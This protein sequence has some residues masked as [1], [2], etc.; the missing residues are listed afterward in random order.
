[1]SAVTRGL[2]TPGD[3]LVT[4]GLGHASTTVSP[5]VNLPLRFLT[6]ASAS[7]YLESEAGASDTVELS[8]QG[9][10]APD[11]SV[12]VSNSF[13]NFNVWGETVEDGPGSQT[14][15]AVASLPGGDLFIRLDPSNDRVYFGTDQDLFDD[16]EVPWTLSDPEVDVFDETRPY[17][18]FVEDAALGSQIVFVMT[19]AGRAHVFTASP[20]DTTARV[21]V[22][23]PAWR[24]PGKYTFDTGYDPTGLTFYFDR[25]AG[26]VKFIQSEPT[27]GVYT[28]DPFYYPDTPDT[29]QFTAWVGRG[30]LTST[31][32][33]YKYVS[34]V[35]VY[36]E[37]DPAVSV[38]TEAE[39][40]TA[41][42][43]APAWT[44]G[45]AGYTVTSVEHESQSGFWRYLD[46]WE[47]WDDY[48][49]MHK[50]RIFWDNGISPRVQLYELRF[51]HN[52]AVNGSVATQASPVAGRG[53]LH[54]PEEWR[55]F[56]DFYYVKFDTDGWRFAYY[57]S[58]SNVRFVTN[59]EELF[60]PYPTTPDTVLQPDPSFVPGFDTFGSAVVGPVIEKDGQLRLLAMQLRPFEYPLND[61][62]YPM[63]PVSAFTSDG[64]Q[65]A[66]F[67]LPLDSDP[68]VLDLVR[69]SS[70]TT[71]DIRAY[72]SRPHDTPED[73]P[74]VVRVA[75]A[76][77]ILADIPGSYPGTVDHLAFVCSDL[78]G[79]L[80][81]VDY[82][83]VTLIADTLAD[84]TVD[85]TTE[86]GVDP[87][88]VD[89]TLIADTAGD[90]L[91][92][93][94]VEVAPDV[95][96][97]PTADAFLDGAVTLLEGA[98]VSIILLSDA[99][100]SGF[101][102]LIPTIEDLELVPS[103]Q[104]LDGAVV[105]ISDYT[106]EVLVLSVAE[107]LLGSGVVLLTSQGAVAGTPPVP[108]T[109]ST[110]PEFPDE[111]LRLPLLPHDAPRRVIL[112]AGA[113]PVTYP[114]EYV[115]DGSLIQ[116]TYRGRVLDTFWH[117]SDLSTFDLWVFD[118]RGN[119]PVCAA[120]V[121]T[122][123]TPTYTVWTGDEAHSFHLMRQGDVLG[124]ETVGPNLII[125]GAGT[126]WVGY[127]HRS[128]TQ[129]TGARMIYLFGY[130]QPTIT[131][132]DAATISQAG[133]G[134]F[135][136]PVS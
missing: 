61:P 74:S 68:L 86:V 30:D 12:I 46:T 11:G 97:S 123:S 108:N 27:E 35:Q 112:P 16:Y 42:F 45:S 44:R 121:V 4:A 2:G 117:G 79:G 98:E 53:F 83:N 67:N 21:L 48:Q 37:D 57:T 87:N 82:D 114:L 71:Y 125:E 23:D 3:L 33:R 127:E 99:A 43:E 115:A 124:T 58:S 54:D 110:P 81:F 55:A 22:F 26:K 109:G 50:Y 78:L 107:Q 85:L 31:A 132:D 36:T 106:D 69:D 80:E 17:T 92:D 131:F 116:V 122:A 25:H 72:V 70:A 28:P 94:T 136:Y 40:K 128:P 66:T 84:G 5:E 52:H 105:P 39:A 7:V 95:T 76:V 38:S 51:G 65:V 15:A 75:A 93:L 8:L 111:W 29:P 59:D 134:R 101:V 14:R 119:L 120:P 104:D 100:L 13:T 56:N 49:W 103:D 64:G 102:Q 118:R 62:Y 1:M 34:G 113:D 130:K 77:S 20:G 135:L 32:Q 90:G 18:R 126:V 6:S 9:D 60:F 96:I 89:I 88:E 24:S 133:Y 19:K 63:N 47:D 129:L 73:L 41:R 91:V 10:L